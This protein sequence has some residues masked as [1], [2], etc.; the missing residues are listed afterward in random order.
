[1]S[2]ACTLN[3][4]TCHVGSTDAQEKRMW[5][6]WSNCLLSQLWDYYRW[7]I[8]SNVFVGQTPWVKFKSF[9]MILSPLV[10]RRYYLN[11]LKLRNI[12]N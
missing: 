11:W 10:K 7:K 12:D 4:A 2:K 5:H 8:V 9:I 1:M 3:L 6:M